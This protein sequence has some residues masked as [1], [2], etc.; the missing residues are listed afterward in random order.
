MT[1]KAVVFDIGNVLIEWQPERFYD[2]EIGEAEVVAVKK[3]NFRA[4]VEP[5]CTLAFGDEVPEDVDEELLYKDDA[6]GEVQDGGVAEEAGVEE[7]VLVH[8][9]VKGLGLGTRTAETE[10]AR[11]QRVHVVLEPGDG[12]EEKRGRSRLAAD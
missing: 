9:L 5:R 12:R 11:P 8:D 1:I 3:I 6:P 7:G 10:P 4:V 2:A